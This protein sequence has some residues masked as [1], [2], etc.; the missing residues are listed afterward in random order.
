MEGRE[1]GKRERRE[2]E[3]KWRVTEDF[4]LSFVPFGAFQIRG[5]DEAQKEK[6][7]QQGYV[8]GALCP[9]ASREG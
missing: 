1:E 5:A 8:D 2:E 9:P 6:P 7:Q 4:S 3:G